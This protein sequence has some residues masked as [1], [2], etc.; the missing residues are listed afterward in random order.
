MIMHV[1]ATRVFSLHW[2]QFSIHCVP[3]LFSR[4]LCEISL[5]FFPVHRWYSFSIIGLLLRW[6]SIWSEDEERRARERAEREDRQSDS[7]VR[8]VRRCFVVHYNNQREYSIIYRPSVVWF[9]LSSLLFL[10]IYDNSS[11][12][13]TS[14]P[15]REKETSDY[16]QFTRF[17]PS[18]P[19]SSSSFLSFF[20][21]LCR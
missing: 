3:F 20:T 1:C 5:F 9:P 8:E 13:P 18:L 4:H 7:R 19:S 16:P 12:L 14:L 11:S 6:N 10:I 17:R 15:G 21:T 2:T